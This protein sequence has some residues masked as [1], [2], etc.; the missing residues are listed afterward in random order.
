MS[1]VITHHAIAR[2][3]ERF[4]LDAGALRRTA[5]R[6]W[7]EGFRREQTAGALRRYCDG[8]YHFEEKHPELRLYGE[9]VFV[10]MGETLI[11]VHHVPGALRGHLVKL[12]R[13]RR[14]GQPI[15]VHQCPSVVKKGKGAAA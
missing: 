11:T 8:L 2:G 9:Q 7:A 5:E 3:R 12:R 15:G 10:F 1:T 6:A 4:S 14:A 13:Q